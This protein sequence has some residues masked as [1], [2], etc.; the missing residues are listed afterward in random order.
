LE[1][2]EDTGGCEWVTIAVKW[3]V[4]VFRAKSV[5][6]TCRPVRAAPGG[7]ARETHPIR[8]LQ[9][10]VVYGPAHADAAIVIGISNCIMIDSEDAI[11]MSPNPKPQMSNS[12]LDLGLPA[13]K[14]FVG[15]GCLIASRAL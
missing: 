10:V 14:F 6:K 15:H 4:V 7:F 13:L 9:F 1:G 11:V 2:F 8:R 12:T 3:K 5:T